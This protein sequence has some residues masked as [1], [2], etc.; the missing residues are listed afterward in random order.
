MSRA[1]NLANLIGGAS[2]GTSGMALPSGTTAQ[3]PSSPTPGIIRYNTESN[4]VE[5]YTTSWSTIGAALGTANNPATSAAAIKLA[6]P[7]AADGLYYITAGG[8]TQQI[9]CDM[10]DANG[11]WMMVSSNY[12][13]DSTIPG[14][15]GRNSASYELDRSGSLGNPS[16]QSDYIIGSIINSLSWNTCR[17]YA[18]GY[19]DLSAART[20]KDSPGTYINVTWPVTGTGVGRLT[21]IQTRANV[22]VT[23]NS[24]LSTNYANYFIVDGV[25]MDN[26]AGA[27][28]NANANQSTVGG[29][30]VTNSNGDPANGTYLGHGTSEGSYEGWYATDASSANCAGYT[31][32]VKQYE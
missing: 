17:V 5:V 7:S 10:T 13:N 26:V 8:I 27:G 3:R 9:Y 20:Y 14:G 24:S 11:P 28:Y 4:L 16:P 29:V 12:Y 22:T 31:T 30:A 23:G 25:K 18:W 2:A 6:I 32:W 15:T 1:K 21:T 19:N